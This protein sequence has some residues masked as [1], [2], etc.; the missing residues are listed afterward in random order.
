MVHWITTQNHKTVAGGGERVWHEYHYAFS[1]IHSKSFIWCWHAEA[2][3]AL[4]ALS[5]QLAAL[6]TWCGLL[7]R[8][9]ILNDRPV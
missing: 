4:A 6:A 2:L 8:P 3:A 5:I 7:Q 9:A 1:F